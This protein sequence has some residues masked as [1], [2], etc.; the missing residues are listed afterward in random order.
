[1]KAHLM[2]GDRDFDIREQPPFGSDMLASDLELQTL[3]PAMAK[4]DSVVFDASSTALMCSLKRPGEIR[5]R[6]G[7]LEDCIKNPA[8]IRE[9][10][11]ITIQ[12][13]ERERKEFWW[14]ST[15]SVA[16]AF[17]N[18]VNLLQALVEMLVKLRRVADANA[19]KF[20][21]EGLSNLLSM[22]QRELNDNYFLLVNEHL[23]EL[24]FRDGALISAH[25]G[26]YNQ[27]VDY[28][29]RRRQKRQFW[30]RWKF[31]PSFTISPRDDSGGQDLSRRK[32]RAINEAANVLAQSAEHVKSFFSMLRDELAFYVGCVNLYEQLQ[33]AGAPVCLPD[34]LESTSTGRLIHGLYDVSLALQIG[35]SVIG[36]D[37]SADHQS[38]FVITGAN[39]GGKSTFLRSIGQA[40]LMMQSGMFVPANAYTSHICT[41]VYSHFKKE[42]DVQMNSGKLDEELARMSS[43]V[44]HLTTGALVL[45]N[46]SFAATNERE[47]SEIGH[48]IVSALMEHGVEIF[49]VTHLFEFANNF[50]EQHLPTVAFLRA[51]RLEDGKRS[52][53][54]IPGDPLKTGFG[55][56]VYQAVFG[57]EAS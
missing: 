28:V 56:D 34:P 55:E 7:V 16:S 31:S 32:E 15:Q 33:K 19:G 30:R 2:F 25:L 45:F 9:L 8:A 14:L 50:H 42:E 27:G 43:I 48:Q 24:K 1:M 18:A 22:L 35:T 17:Y 11:S 26:N 5:Y 20:Q 52:F 4:G 23:N 44:D 54:I 29:L 36:N 38:L 37:L 3:L 57:S 41:G 12:T 46:E 49:F 53:R 13:I 21:S 40:Q 6:Q 47:G 51:E 10:Y 39:Q